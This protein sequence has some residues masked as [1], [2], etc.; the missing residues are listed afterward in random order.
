MTNGRTEEAQPVRTVHSVTS[1]DGEPSLSPTAARADPASDKKATAEAKRARRSEI[2][3]RSRQ[4]R[5]G[6]V[7]SMRAQL[8]ALEREYQRLVHGSTDNS[9]TDDEDDDDNNGK[10][11]AA[12]FRSKYLAL[13]REAKALRDQQARL[14]RM[15]HTRQLARDSI[16]A[17]SAEF[18]RDPPAAFELRWGSVRHASIA[19]LDVSACFSLIR[20][21]Y[22]AIRQ[23]DSSSQFQT[24]G[25][26]MFGWSDKRRL[27]EDDAKMLFS[28]S[29]LLP[30][31]NAEELLRETWRT[32]SDEAFMRRVIFPPRVH[33]D[34]RRVQ[35][36]NEDAAVFHRHTTYHH[37][38]KSF[39]T[40]YLL[41]RVRTDTGYIV[42]FRTIPAPAL[43]S[44]MEP[45]E[46]WIDLF[47]W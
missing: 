31:R 13:A 23:F 21:S 46:A 4:R 7:Q 37:L 43:Q 41:F 45:H 6:G 12:E 22:E 25:S 27:A 42:C 18:V 26:S 32:Y 19:P 9:T 3:R 10:H 29:K 47:H 39:H 8:S 33:V 44:A 24:T 35:V 30:N 34:L 40:V 1:S 36:V 11:T 14:Q 2:E 17:L 38:G 28:F 16:R 5:Q 15:L 20:E